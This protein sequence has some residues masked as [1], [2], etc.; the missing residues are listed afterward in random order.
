MQ[1]E[2]RQRQRSSAEPE[3]EFVRCVARRR[4]F[5]E[6][7]DEYNPFDVYSPSEQ[8]CPE[9]ASLSDW[10]QWRRHLIEIHLSVLHG[11]HV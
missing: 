6:S 4:G 2:Q 3:V 5:N 10:N 9:E 8:L 7:C 1:E 11:T